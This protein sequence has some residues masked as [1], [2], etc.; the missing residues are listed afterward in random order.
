MNGHGP[1]VVRGRLKEEHKPETFN[2]L[3]TAEEQSRL[4]ELL[5][6]F[7]PERVEARRWEKIARALGN[8]TTQQVFVAKLQGHT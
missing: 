1:V 5:L 8:R 4:E 2:V 7:P 3:W 6:K